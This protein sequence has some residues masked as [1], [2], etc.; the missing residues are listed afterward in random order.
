MNGK[1]LYLQFPKISYNTRCGGRHAMIL[2][3]GSHWTVPWR[4]SVGYFRKNDV[5]R[6]PVGL[7][8]TTTAVAMVSPKSHQLNEKR[9]YTDTDR[10]TT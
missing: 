9:N 2:N 10:R 8:E 3:S 4:Q 1:E 6:S 7:A 5:L